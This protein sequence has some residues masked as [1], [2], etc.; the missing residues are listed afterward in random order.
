MHRY[1]LAG[2]LVLG[3]AFVGCD[4]VTDDQEV[5]QSTL[6]GS[7]ENP[8]R[9]TAATGTAQY[10]VVDNNTIHYTVEVTN[11]TNTITLGHIH[12]GGAGVNGGVIVSLIDVNGVLAPV[13][14]F[15]TTTGN[16][17][18][19]EGTITRSTPL[20]LGFT[21]DTLLAAMRAQTAYTNFHSNVFGGGEIRGQVVPVTID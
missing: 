21:F 13:P 20:A 9:A 16:A 10:V 15:R 14:N 17:I 7:N 18:L 8:P 3:L 12:S 6:L 4:K 11:F 5:F 1:A 2:A 19:V